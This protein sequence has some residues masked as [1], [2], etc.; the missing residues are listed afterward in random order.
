MLEIY[1]PDRILKLL[2]TE[3]TFG[4]YSASLI[5]PLKNDKLAAL[6]KGRIKFEP[7]G[8]QNQL[9]FLLVEKRS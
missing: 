6:Q 1:I 7:V 4:K 3:K 2:D 5:D 9:V 8:K